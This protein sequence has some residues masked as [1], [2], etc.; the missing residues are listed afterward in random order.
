MTLRYRS[1]DSDFNPRLPLFLSNLLVPQLIIQR[2]HYP[3]KIRYFYEHD[4]SRCF[5]ETVNSSW[6]IINKRIKPMQNFK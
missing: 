1:E 4:K 5:N 2:C 3:F 6:T